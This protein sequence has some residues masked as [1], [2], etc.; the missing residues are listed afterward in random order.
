MPDGEANRARSPT[1]RSPSSTASSCWRC[2]CA[3][4][5]NAT[6]S[7][8]E[9]EAVYGAEGTARIGLALER[10]LAGLD[11]LGIE[12]GLALSVV[13]AVALDSVPPAR[14]R[15]YEHL[16]ALRHN[17]KAVAST[18]M[19]AEVLALPSVTIRRVLEDLTAY[20]LIERR[21][22]GRGRADLWAVRDWEREL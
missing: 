14:R 7:S 17:G 8:R 18:T 20:G 16:C 15:A 12:R 21:A 13:K 9:I 2:G 1:T 6:A 10:L 4:R 19:V 22:Q 3:A 5:S 11:T